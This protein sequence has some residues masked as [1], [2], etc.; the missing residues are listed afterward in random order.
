MSIIG[1][2]LQRRIILSMW[3]RAQKVSGQHS[4]H[5]KWLNYW[6]LS[7][8]VLKGSIASVTSTSAGLQKY[9]W[10]QILSC[11]PCLEPCLNLIDFLLKFYLYLSLPAHSSLS[12]FWREFEQ[13]R[14]KSVFFYFRPRLK[15]IVRIKCSLHSGAVLFC[16]RILGF[17]SFEVPYFSVAKMFTI[18]G[19]V[20]QNSS[21]LEPWKIFNRTSI[22]K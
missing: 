5:L 7:W 19:T 20:S 12:L 16:V 4:I 10:D 18:L 21:S 17:G 3:G 11:E 1:T 14:F 22:P 9:G 15:K 6:E 2:K 13:Q 8:C